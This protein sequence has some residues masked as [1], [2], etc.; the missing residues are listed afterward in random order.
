MILG[1][2][3]TRQCRFCAV[4]KGKTEAVDPK[5][6]ENIGTACQEMGLKH[7]VVTSVTR[8]DLPDG[9][10][11]HFAETVAEI[12]RRNPSSTVELLIPDLKGNWEALKTIA[13]AK[14][15]ILNHNLETVKNLYDTVRPQA[16]YERS[17][18][19]LKTMKE[20]DPGI[21]TKSGIMVGLGETEEEVFGLMDDLRS[22][23]CDILTI[24]QYLRPSEQHIAIKEYVHP[25][26]FEKYKKKAEEKGFRYVAS[27]PFVRSSYNAALGINSLKGSFD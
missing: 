10:A 15:D 13:D 19:L 23:D 20:F 25:D 11:K 9:G 4:T 17:L 24:G 8:D 18:E 5:E 7:V 16:D 22:I 12:R 26:R 21:Y 6:P 2:V 27:G 3:C 14:P 1:S